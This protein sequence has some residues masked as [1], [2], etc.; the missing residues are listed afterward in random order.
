MLLWTHNYGDNVLAEYLESKI[1][2]YQVKDT[3]C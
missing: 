2:R 3:L 1:K